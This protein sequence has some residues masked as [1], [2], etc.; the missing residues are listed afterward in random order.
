MLTLPA[1]PDASVA[2]LGPDHVR[3][4]TDA[5]TRFWLVHLW[6]PTAVPL[7][8]IAWLQAGADRTIADALFRLQGGAW[9][10]R[11]APWM[12]QGVHRAGRVASIGAWLAV[13]MAYAAHARLRVAAWRQ[14]AGYVLVAVAAATC[15][16]SL[17]K[18][19]THVDCP[20]DLLR[21]GGDRPWHGVFDA[22]RH[23]L[24]GARCFPAGHASAGYAWLAL[25][26][27]AREAA[28]RLRITALLPGLCAGI[29]FGIG[30]QLRGAHFASHD[31]ASALACW[32]VALGLWR[33]WPWR[34]APGDGRPAW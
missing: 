22:Q 8:A 21:Y 12:E 20:W 19:A 32:L 27:A 10:W 2:T 17:L 28:P 30:Q 31:V 5:S 14:A 25:Y 26:L 15:A 4:A 18:A 13:A 9:A 34:R 16:V 24:P 11:H 23:A 7:L 29:A 6:L 3:V 33:V 1:L